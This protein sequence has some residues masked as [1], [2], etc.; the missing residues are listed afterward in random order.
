[1][2]PVLP[3]GHG[4]PLP[5]PAH[6]GTGPGGESAAL[7]EQVARAIRVARDEVG[8]QR[9]ERDPARVGGEDRRATGLVAHVSRSVER[10]ALQR[11]GC[12]DLHERV[13]AV[14][15]VAGREV[16]SAALERDRGTV[17]RDVG[18]RRVVVAL[19][20]IRVDRDVHRRARLP[21]AQE[22]V[23]ARVRVE[24]DEVGG[25]ALERDVAAVGGDRRVR[26]VAVALHSAGVDADA[27]DRTRH[28]V[29]DEHV[30]AAVRVVRHQV[31]G[32]APERDEAPVRAQLRAVQRR[33]PESGSE[34]ALD[35]SRIRAG[36]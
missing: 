34:V 5:S 8:G 25:R 2:D 11:A 19:D 21:I 24:R 29:L 14:V 10:D 22:H 18:A 23:D 3:H 28:E 31:G 13:E 7:H 17:G 32:R 4:M 1:M 36:A 16:R 27:L 12:D 6:V 15:R 33:R 35:A 9:V 26:R 20:P 30:L